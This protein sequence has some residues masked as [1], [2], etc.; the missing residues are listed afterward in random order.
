MQKV[1]WMPFK[2]EDTSPEASPRLSET[3][4]EPSAPIVI[5]PWATHQSKPPVHFKRLIV[6][7]LGGRPQQQK[8]KTVIERNLNGWLTVLGLGAKFPLD[9]TEGQYYY[10]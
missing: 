1:A 3:D 6:S 8:K 7:T 5:C 2:K 9:F 10:E 4:S